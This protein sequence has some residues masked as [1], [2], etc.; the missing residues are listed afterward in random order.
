MSPALTA[1][2]WGDHQPWGRAFCGSQ[3]KLLGQRRVWGTGDWLP[4]TSGA[5]PTADQPGT[6]SREVTSSSV[7]VVHQAGGPP[8]GQ[9]RCSPSPQTPSPGWGRATQRPWAVP[10]T[11]AVSPGWRVLRGGAGTG[12]VQPPPSFLS[13]QLRAPTRSPQPVW[14]LGSC[15][16]RSPGVMQPPPQ[17]L[18]PALLPLLPPLTFIEMSCLK[19]PPNQT[20]VLTSPAS[21]LSPKAPSFPRESPGGPGGLAHGFPKTHGGQSP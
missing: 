14:G 5:Q 8:G 2:A 4:F 10:P 12:R 11:W 13:S 1:T 7:S 18:A 16:V 20:L 3:N 21:W 6:L 17:F 15:R 9:D 19:F